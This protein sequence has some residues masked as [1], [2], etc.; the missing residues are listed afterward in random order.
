MTKNTFVLLTIG[1]CFLGLTV[2]AATPDKRGRKYDKEQEW[3]ISAESYLQRTKLDTIDFSCPLRTQIDTLYK[4]RGIH[5]DFSEEFAYHTLRENDVVKIYQDLRHDL[6]VSKRKKLQVNVDGLPLE[7][8]VPVYYWPKKDKS[9][10]AK[11]Y[12]GLMNVQ[13]TSQ[14]FNI[15]K[16]LNQRH[17]ALWNS[18]GRYYNHKDD[19]W[20]W[21]RAPLFST[22]EDLFTSAYILPFLAPMLE[23]A[24]ANIYLPRERDVQ[25]HELIVDN[26]D[27]GFSFVGNI[28]YAYET[29]FRNNVALDSS[30]VNPFT[31]GTYDVLGKTA[32]ATWNL[33]VPANGNY[34]VYVSYVTVDKSCEEAEYRIYHPAG[35]TRYVVNQQMG[36]GTWIYLGNFYFEKDLPAKI[37]LKGS[38]KGF[39]T[40]D[41]VRLGG[42]MGSIARGGKLSAVP[43]WQEAARYYLQYAGALD[44]ITFNR[45]GDTIDYNDDF[46]SRARWVNYLKGGESIEPA[47]RQDTEIKGL[48]IPIDLS[49]GVHTDAGHF[50]SM[51]TIVGTLAIYSTYDVAQQR[52]FYYGKSRLSNRDLADM[53]QTQLVDDLRV[54]HDEE[55]TKRELWDKMY[56]EA[57]FAQCPS[58]LL[59]ILG[60]AN[61]QDMRYGLD[62]QFRFDASR[63]IYKGILR[64]LSSYY[65]ED[66]TVQPLAVHNMNIDDKSGTMMLRWDAT[67]D[68][69]E[70]TATPDAYVVYTRINHKG[71]DNGVR[72]EG[73]TF[74]LNVTDTLLRSYKVTAVNAGGESFPSTIVSM[75]MKSDTL[76]TVLVVDAFTR[77]SAPFFME[78]G[79]S[80]GLAPWEDEGVAWGLDL[81]TIGWQYNYDQRDPWKSDDIPGHGGSF[82]NLSD[83]VFVGNGFDN[84]YAHAEAIVAAGYNVV[85]TTIAA[86]ENGLVDLS[87]F[88]AVDI[89]YGEQRTT[90]LPSGKV[91]F[92]I[93]TPQMM[94]RL[95]E[96]LRNDEARLLIS[97][98]HIANEALVDTAAELMEERAR[99]VS[100]NLGFAYAGQMNGACDSV[101]VKNDSLSFG[102]NT[103]YSQ[104]QYRVENADVLE[105]RNGATLSLIYEEGEGAVVRYNPS[106]RVVSS[107]VPFESIKGK[108][109]RQT[110]MKYYLEYL[111][112]E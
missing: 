28:K 106:Y 88:D 65:Q 8:Y 83:S 49:L 86:V 19:V 53:V 109:E 5:I 89:V 69:L 108:D 64:F 61:A 98:A 31:M 101:F 4:K 93:Y 78:S 102:Y 34:A 30:T 104:E 42:G 72:V 54:L 39:V 47:L 50:L 21:Q 11:P 41:A 7:Q 10:V 51:D 77:V 40:A 95:R 23:N 103:D 97:G 12:Q 15:S 13:N 52:D 68:S 55:W 71:W 105:P 92:D 96:Y 35:V 94:R 82:N 107:G 76:P 43:R 73:T 79:D 2:G 16:G 46:R 37:T 44:S 25:T 45:H 18:H 66:Y 112:N 87:H 80:V 58:M 14:P 70:P 1:L 62:P 57:T 20:K 24:G 36:G 6:G 81:A 67:I 33:E 38:D 26:D 59:E 74:D 90:T 27:E 3:A 111:F 29:G 17:I 56:S 100:Q 84:A 9:K 91:K 110:L 60:H 99:F 48:N 75:A 63:A 85:S 32:L 22:V